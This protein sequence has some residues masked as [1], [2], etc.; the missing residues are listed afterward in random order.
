MAVN[1]ISSAVHDYMSKTPSSL[2]FMEKAK[3]VMPNGV[4]ANIKAFAPYPVVMKKAKGAY[5]YDMDD[6][7]YVDYLLAYGS[8]MLGHGHPKVKEA[9]FNQLESD[10][11]SLFGTP[12][13][14][15][16][17]MGKRLKSYYPSMELLRYT[18]SGTEATLLALRLASAYTGRHKVAKF[19]GHY[20]GGYDKVL[21]SINPSQ[22]EYG[23]EDEPA[24]VQESK[25]IPSYYEDN[26]LILPFNDI[27]KT[28]CLLRKH[29]DNLAALILEPVQSGFIP[30]DPEFMKQLRTITEELGIVLIFDEVKTGFRLGL[31]GAQEVY[32]IKPDL[33]ALGKV[34]GGGFPV[35]VVGGKKE[36][37]LESAAGLSSDV[38]D[39]SQ[40]KT[41]NSKNVLFH[42]GTYNGHPGILA[43]G[44][45][46]LDVL[47]MKMGDVLHH[48][49]TLKTRLEQLFEENGLPMKAVG[50]GTIFNLIP[51][52]QDEIKDYRQFQKADLELRKRLD[53][54]LLNEGIYT[55]PLNRYSLSTE[56]GEEEIEK[57]VEAFK[58]AIKKLKAEQQ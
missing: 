27:E 22:Q 28:E 44:M 36:I 12:H 38:F 14:L 48:T 18:N 11:T 20:H 57:T 40:S 31:G 4:T 13:S 17:E 7:A 16:Y 6:N 19:E 2:A 39:Y 23:A 24:A 34:I 37:M 5:L 56:H 51:T 25:G 47:E 49:E 55:K 46:V 41:S 26:I 9:M 1:K 10:G 33:T 54:H 3:D 43:A 35:G 32:G 42:S 58:R 29:K 15:E 45:A 8:L 53:Y 50:K 52:D 21:F 30:A